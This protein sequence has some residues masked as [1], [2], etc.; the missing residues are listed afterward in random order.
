MIDVFL[1]WFTGDL[2]WKNFLLC[3]PMLA[4]QNVKKPW[5]SEEEVSVTLQK[6]LGVALRISPRMLL[7]TS[8]SDHRKTATCGHQDWYVLLQV[9]YCATLKSIWHLHL[10]PRPILQLPKY[11][12]KYK[13]LIGIIWTKMLHHIASICTNY[14]QLYHTSGVTFTYHHFNF[15]WWKSSVTPFFRNDSF[16]K[17]VKP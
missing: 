3:R 1:S 8:A 16:G 12:V 4:R 13:E 17:Y 2:T 10:H 11:Y 14:I 7:E 15:V 5:G 9:L 6:V